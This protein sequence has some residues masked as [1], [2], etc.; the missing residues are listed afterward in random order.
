ML[1]LTHCTTISRAVI[2]TVICCEE[3]KWYFEISAAT[4]DD[5]YVSVISIGDEH[6]DTVD[7]TVVYGLYNWRNW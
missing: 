5:L 6:I 4:Q 7:N 1:F 2:T 3:G